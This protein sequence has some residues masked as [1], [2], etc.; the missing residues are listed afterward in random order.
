MS[1]IL[2]PALLGLTFMLPPMEALTCQ[3]GIWEA[4]KKTS[5]MPLRWTAEEESCKEGWGCQDSL[6]LIE[7]GPQV[8]LELSKGCT[9]EEDHE[10]RITQHRKSPGLSVVSYTRVCRHKNLCNDLSSTRPVWTLPT[11]AVPGSVRCPVCFSEE[12]CKSATELTCPIGNTHCY[13]GVLQLR[14]IGIHTNL[15]VQGCMSQAACNLLNETQEIGALSVREKCDSDGVKAL[16]CEFGRLTIVRK[17]SELPVRWTTGQ[18]SCKEGWGCQDSLMLIENGPEV[19]LALIKGCTQKEDHE[20]RVTQH[21]EGPG[22]SVVSYTRVC[23]HKNFCNDLTST[24]PVWTLPTPAVPGSVR[25]PVCFSEESCESATELTCPIG[26][27][28]C[29]N[30][31]LQLRGVGTFTDLK[32]Q[33]CMSQA[34]CNL[35]NDTQEIGALSVSEKCDSDGVQALTCQAGTLRAVRKTSEL[36]LEWTTGEEFCKDG[37][38][39]QDSLML[40]ENGPQVL[41]TF[42]KG[43]TQKEDHEARVTQHRKGPGLSVVS[44]TRVCRHKN[45]CND[46]STSLPVWTLPTSEVPGSVRC[47]VCFSEEGCKSAT[48]LTCPVGNTHCYNG[49][50]QLRGVGIL[51]DLK[52]QGCMSQAACN[53]LNETQEIGAL[54]VSEKCD[55]VGV[56]RP[57]GKAVPNLQSSA[58]LTCQKGIMLQMKENLTQNPLPWDTFSTITCD[59]KEVCQETLLLIDVG[60]KSLMVGSKGCSKTETQNSTTISIHSAPPG[61]LVASYAHFCSSDGCNRATSSSVLLNSL[62]PPAA[63]APGGLQCPACVQFGGS[64]SN[65]VNVMCPPGTTHC[66]NGYL[67]LKGGGLSAIFSIQG[68]MAQPS[69]SLLN[70]AKNIGQFIASEGA[71]NEDEE[72]KVRQSGAVPVRCLAW[73]VGLGISFALWCGITSH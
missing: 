67:N 25:C 29:Y 4:V 61:V 60:P 33:G 65:S 26:H 69:S 42:I 40:I 17:A 64:C 44:Y 13:N 18:E 73:V 72:D 58:P 71:E 23:R 3:A 37:W 48:E 24:D 55:S 7:N 2:L 22:L 57:D 68:C 12:G 34:A 70:H 66:Y 50:L 38:G 49:V 5:E 32:V 19:F 45:L 43:C 9:Q 31:T 15:K 63:P 51:T 39:C 56:P 28:H 35:L 46:L 14:G 41:L 8:F 16:T 6:M 47:P 52:V 11:F 27:T 30:G 20:A 53:L 1:S 62:P 10:A 59:L 54:S 36:P 21:R